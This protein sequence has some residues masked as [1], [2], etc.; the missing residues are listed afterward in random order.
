ENVPGNVKSAARA[1]QVYE[2]GDGTAV[3]EGVN[4]EY[5]LMNVVGIPG[6]V[7]TATFTSADGESVTVSLEDL[8]AEGYNSESG[9]GNLPA[10]LA[11][12]KNGAPLVPDTAHAGYTA[13]LPLA[14]FT[15]GDPATFAVD[16]QGGPLMLAVPSTGR[17]SGD[18]CTL[19]N[20][21]SL[22]VDIRPDSYAHLSG[23]AAA[24]SGH[25]IRFFGE[26]LEKEASF[27]VADLESRQRQARTLDYSVMNK[28]GELKEQRYRGIPLYELFTEIGIRANA[29]EVTI[30]A[31]DGSTTVV[32]LAKLKGQTF[33]NYVSPD[34]KQLC[35]MLAYGS[36]TV[37]GE[38]TEGTPLTVEDGGPVRLMVPMG[39]ADEVNTSLS[40]KNVAAIE[41]SANEVTTWSHS[42]S[43]VYSEFLGYEMTLT[44]RNEAN[45]WSH[46]FTLAQLESLTD[47]IVRQDYTVLELGTCEGLDLW[48]FVKKFAGSVP[49]IEAPISVTTYAEDGYKNDLLSNVYLEGLEQGVVND[50]GERVPVIISY[51]F[52]GI[53]LVDDA[54]HPGYTGLAGNAGGPLRTVVENILGASLKTF[55]KLVVT[56]PGSDA[57]SLTV[58]ESLFAAAN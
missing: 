2:T 31:T 20:V 49:G 9:L 48:K 37:D 40:V 21:V 18:A 58:D 53:P 34:K 3:L 22:T 32:P 38:I 1:K 13:T 30:H 11:F 45:E 8:F 24:L 47:L 23:E 14:P 55:N 15:E 50:S 17:D 57:I 16:N 29:G 12:A 4:I 7:G 42:M 41:V 25:S 43:D 56:I 5:F 26:G 44:I 36:G 33:V 54:D 6:T 39:A 52:N 19:E 10:I 28:K 35:A 27:T 46:V 51:A